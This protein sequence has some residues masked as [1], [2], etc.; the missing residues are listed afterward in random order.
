M[1]R[2]LTFTLLG[3][4]ASASLAQPG[5]QRVGPRGPRSSGDRFQPTD[6]AFKSE[7]TAKIEGEFRIIQANGIP[8]HQTGQ[9]P[10]RGNPHSIQPQ[11]YSYR[12]PADPKV[13]RTATPLGMY[14]FGIAVNG[15]VYDPRAAEWW[16]GARNSIW[17]YEPLT[18]HVTL[19][20][21]MN[22]AHVQPSGA[23]HYHGVPTELFKRK[24][25]GKPEMILLGWAADGFP[26]YGPYGLN[27]PKNSKSGVRKMK[28]SYQLKKGDRPAGNQG[29]GGAYDGSFTA[30]WTYVKGLGDLDECNGRFGV[31]PEFPTGICHY[32]ITD[33]F[34]FVSRQF[35]GTPDSSFQRR[36]GPGGNRPPP[37]QRPRKR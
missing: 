3:A 21:D 13:A 32:Y 4:L 19:G 22:D 26:M 2:I 36:G 29:P 12:V 9:F 18:S 37:G 23:Y 30:D 24:T 11:N 14:P 10:N 1:K 17:Q 5:Q 33:E 34:P 28:T 6:V 20:A 35:R 7:F 31:T 25:G 27:D 15:V 8:D 16:N